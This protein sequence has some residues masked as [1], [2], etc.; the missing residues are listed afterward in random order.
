VQIAQ[1]L[2]NLIRNSCDAI[3]R[4]AEKWIRIAVTRLPDS[5]EISVSDS[6]RGIPENVREKIFQPFFTTKEVGR[7]TGLGLSVSKGIVE[8]HGGTITLDTKSTHT[9]FVVTL[10]LRGEQD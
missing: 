5:I 4:G 8:A 6:G 7:G 9:R 1:V 3:E 2:L 10:P